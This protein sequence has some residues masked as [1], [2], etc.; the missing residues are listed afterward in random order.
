MGNVDFGLLE[1]N[2][3]TGGDRERAWDVRRASRLLSTYLASRC[4]KT[5]MHDLSGRQRAVGKTAVSK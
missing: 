3:V 4:I 5:D 1:S 2:T